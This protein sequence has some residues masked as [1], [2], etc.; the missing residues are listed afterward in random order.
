MHVNQMLV[1]CLWNT[2]NYSL[3]QL[4]LWSIWKMSCNEPIWAQN[5]TN[6]VCLGIFQIIQN[7]R[8]I[9]RSCNYKSCSKLHLLSPQIFFEFFSPRSY[10]SW[11]KFSFQCLNSIGNYLGAAPPVT[12]SSDRADPTPSPRL[13]GWRHRATPS[14]W[15]SPVSLPHCRCGRCA[16][17]AHRSVLPPLTE[18]DRLVYSEP[19]R[20][21]LSDAVHPHSPLFSSV[22]RRSQPKLRVTIGTVI[23][24]AFESLPLTPSVLLAHRSPEPWPVTIENA[25]SAASAV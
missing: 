11:G 16:A 15:S 20:C 13:H 6:L 2:I 24:A 4:E 23:A 10:F 8:R 19:R 9:R 18:A 3:P 21:C 25:E 17:A 5:W 14:L 7:P 1:Q 22:P 12:S